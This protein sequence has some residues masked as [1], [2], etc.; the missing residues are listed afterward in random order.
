MCAESVDS[1]L[2]CIQHS[3]FRVLLASYNL[4]D[5]LHVK[6]ADQSIRRDV[7]P[8]AAGGEAAGHIL[9]FFTSTS[10]AV[11][12]FSHA[13]CRAWLEPAFTVMSQQTPALPNGPD[14]EQ[15]SLIPPNTAAGLCYYSLG[16]WSPTAYKLCFF[17]LGTQQ[18]ESAD[19]ANSEDLMD[20]SSHEACNLQMMQQAMKQ[21]MKG[22]GGQP[23]Q[24]GQS[25]N[26]FGGMAGM[27]GGMPGGM[28]PGF[29]GTPG[30]MGHGWPPA[31]DTTAQPTGE[32]HA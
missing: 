16:L 21:A 28:P 18:G 14:A 4:N 31:V 23:G 25:P 27:P 2:G 5:L 13:P 15:Q 24:P 22:M 32:L 7:F 17:V 26:P 3:T 11:S 8:A 29:P 10:M 12:L 6:S 9:C 30:Q 20:H 19:K 1:R